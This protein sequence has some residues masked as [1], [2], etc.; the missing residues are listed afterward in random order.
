MKKLP[1]S[2]QRSER[3]INV[4]QKPNTHAAAPKILDKS[5]K[6]LLCASSSFL[7]ALSSPGIRNRQNT[8]IRTRPMLRMYNTRNGNPV[9]TR[10]SQSKADCHS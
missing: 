6:S 1:G 9:P 5:P 7:G 2:S 3:L 8:H 4:T 10:F